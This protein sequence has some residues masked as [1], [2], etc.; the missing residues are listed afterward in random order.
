[1]PK[2]KVLHNFFFHTYRWRQ[3][4][5]SS[6]KKVLSGCILKYLVNI[7]NGKYKLYIIRNY[8]IYLLVLFFVLSSYQISHLSTYQCANHCVKRVR[9]Q[10]YSGPYFPTFGLNTGTYGV[11]LRIQSECGKIRTI[12]T[13]N[14]TLFTQWVWI[15]YCMVSSTVWPIFSE[16]LI[17]C[18]F[19]STAF[20]SVK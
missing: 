19:I 5:F 13:P 12:I 14:R 3:Y 18:Q 6:I 8:D 11:S 2:Y 15:S 4:H 10:S 20:R 9:I 7:S 1:M 16:F 17:F